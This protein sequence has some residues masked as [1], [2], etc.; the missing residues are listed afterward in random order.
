ML[1]QCV[2][3]SAGATISSIFSLPKRQL[4]VAIHI[5][6]PWMTGL[7]NGNLWPCVETMGPGVR[8]PTFQFSVR[9]C[10]HTRTIF[11]VS[12]HVRITNQCSH[13]AKFISSTLVCPLT[14]HPIGSLT[15][16]SLRRNKSSATVR[17]VSAFF[18]MMCPCCNFKPLTSSASYVQGF[19]HHVFAKPVCIAL[20][21]PRGMIMQH[22][23]FHLQYMK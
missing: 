22:K 18:P 10:P 1:P 2:R 17:K 6:F 23:W 13:K 12:W 19:F 14:V 7:A 21:T 16:I 9:L 8:P 11:F 3:W 20:T 5:W 15:P 4:R